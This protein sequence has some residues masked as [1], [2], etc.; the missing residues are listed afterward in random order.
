LAII[1]L[2]CYFAAKS[3]KEPIIYSPKLLLL[4]MSSVAN[5]LS[6]KTANIISVTPNT[7]VFDALQ[8]MAQK[9]IGSVIV[10]SEGIYLG[11][12]TE[13]DY[14]RKIILQDKHSN[15]TPVSEIMSTDLPRI[16]PRDSHESCMKLMAEK[17]VRYLPVFEQGQLVGIISLIDVIQAT[18][19]KQKETIGSLQDFISS[20][21]A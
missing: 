21:F 5:I 10:M 4:R 9:N 6:R 2:A 14:A 20:N 11:L 17:N 8:I 18:V 16:S 7:S 12:L 1:K 19:E 3:K 13:R 15:E